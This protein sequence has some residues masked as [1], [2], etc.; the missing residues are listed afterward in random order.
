MKKD[1]FK[2]FITLCLK[3]VNIDYIHS[4]LVVSFCKV[5][6]NTILYILLLRFDVNTSK[7]DKN[8]YMYMSLLFLYLFICHV[9]IRLDRQH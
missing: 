4:I 8:L 1:L 2:N 5:Y 3:S 7:I 9:F 6:S